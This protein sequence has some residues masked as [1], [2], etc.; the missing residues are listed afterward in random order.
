[1]AH[2]K[3]I[4]LFPFLANSPNLLVDF[5]ASAWLGIPP[6]A[7]V[8]M[9]QDGLGPARSALASNHFWLSKSDLVDWKSW[10]RTAD[11]DELNRIGAI[12]RKHERGQPPRRLFAAFDNDGPRYFRAAVLAP[13]KR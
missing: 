2:Q 3:R 1:M 5:L 7:L 12:V 9:A 6:G 10:A 4:D 8:E 13:K 11:S